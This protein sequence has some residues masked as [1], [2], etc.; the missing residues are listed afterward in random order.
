MRM[1]FS[2]PKCLF[3]VRMVTVQLVGCVKDV[4]FGG[5]VIVVNVLTD[6]ARIYL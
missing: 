4:M 3:G 1:E 2:Y 5:A 6:S